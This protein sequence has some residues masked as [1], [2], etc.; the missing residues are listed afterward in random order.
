MIISTVLASALLAAGP[1][2]EFVDGLG[3]VNSKIVSHCL[4]VVGVPEVDWLQD[5][6]WEQF[7]DCVN[8]LRHRKGKR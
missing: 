4:I 6:S 1:K 3:W 7:G 5:S 2:S 8:G